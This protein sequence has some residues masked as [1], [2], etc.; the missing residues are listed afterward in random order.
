MPPVE[1]EAMA[2]APASSLHRP[3]LQAVH[4]RRDLPPALD[5][6]LIPRQR[7]RADALGDVDLCSV[8]VLALDRERFGEALLG[9]RHRHARLSRAF[10]T[11]RNVSSSTPK[12]R[13]SLRR[14]RS[15]RS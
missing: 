10:G 3:A 8:A 2:A 6:S 1:R 5:T 4:S 7:Q 13:A 11:G 9:W 12:Y 14:S 15:A